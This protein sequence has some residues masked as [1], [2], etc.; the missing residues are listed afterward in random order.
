MSIA[1]LK[2]GARHGVN[3]DEGTPDV[4]NAGRLLMKLSGMHSHAIIQHGTRLLIGTE[5]M[6]SILE[7]LGPLARG[8]IA[9]TFRKQ[10]EHLLAA[11]DDSA[12]PREYQA[13]LLAEVN[14]YLGVLEQ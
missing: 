9:K 6:V 1:D 8:E 3:F 5:L 7:H 12:L 13:E 10:V 4:E 2:I 14:R 11:G